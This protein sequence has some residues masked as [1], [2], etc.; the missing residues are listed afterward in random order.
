MLESIV[1]FVCATVLLFLTRSL[2]YTMHDLGW[3]YYGTQL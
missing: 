1:V 3:L 2:N